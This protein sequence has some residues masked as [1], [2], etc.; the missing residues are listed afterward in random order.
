V[1]E[2]SVAGA[3]LETVERHARG[4]PVS[5]VNLRVGRLRQVVPESLLF[6]WGIVAR[7]TVCD[8]SRLDLVDVHARLRCGECEHDWEPE[9]AIF[10]CTECG[11]GEVA[12]AA[13]DEL[14]VEYIEVEEQEAAC[15][16]QR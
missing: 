13:G 11:S 4:R 8:G 2:L 15:I 9:F 7:D 3:V 5:V 6:Y 12:I 16:G 10:R 1:H 14:E